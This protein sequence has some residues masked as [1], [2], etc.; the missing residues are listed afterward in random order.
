MEGKRNWKARLICFLAL[1]V[2]ASVSGVGTD[3]TINQFMHRSWTAKDGGPSVVQ[4]L[5][6]TKDGFLWLGTPDGLYRFDGIAFDRFECASWSVFPLLDVRSLRATPN[7]DLWIGFG[8]GVASVLRNGNVRN[9]T[10]A[11]GMPSGGV[12]GFAQDR[13]G[14][15]WAATT[16][17]LA[18]LESD[19]WKEVGND[20]NFPGRLA[21]GIF[22]DRHGTLWVAT[23]NSIVFLPAG[24]KKFQ[25]TGLHVGEVWQFAEA[26]NGKLWMAETTRSVRPVPLNNERLPRDSTEVRVGS[27]AILFDRDGALWITTLGDGMRRAAVPTK[28]LG[29]IGEFSTTVE[30]FSIKDGLSADDATAILQDNEGNVWVGTHKGLDCFR[31]TNLAPVALPFSAVQAVL[32][33]GDNGDIWVSTKVGPF[34]TR[35]HESRAEGVIPAGFREP[36]LNSYRSPDGINWWV[37]G[38]AVYRS[39]NGRF[40][41]IPLP[42]G[43]FTPFT[44]G[45]LVAEDGFHELWAAAGNNGLFRLKGNRWTKF[46]AGPELE[47]LIPAAAF[48]DWMGRVWFGYRGGTIAILGG[49][50]IEKVFSPRQS[51][52]GSVRAIDGVNGHV[53][54]GGDWGLA[55]LQGDNFHR[56]IPVDADQFRTVWGIVET[57]EG[58]LWLSEYR[59]VTHLPSAEVRKALDSR[60]YRVKYELFDSLDGLPG[61]FREAG[62]RSK[63]IKANDGR[64]WFAASDGIATLDPARTFRNELPPPVSILSVRADEKQFPPKENVTLPA[65]T[66]NLQIR[67]TGLSLSVPE[68]VYF[69]YKLEGVDND[70]QDA[71]TRRE[72]FYTNLRPGAY[73]FRVVASN[74]DGVWNEQGAALDFSIA[75]AWF[76]TIWFRVFCIAITMLIAWGIYRLRLRQIAKAMSAHFNDRLAERTRLARELHDTFLQTLQASKFVTDDALGNL[77]DPIR[78]RRALEQ[79]SRWLA[80]AMQEWRT[81]LHSLRASSTEA[82]D[83]A[84]AFRRALEDCRRD[85]STTASLSVTGD[86][87]ELHPVVRDEI[88][89]IGYEAIRNAC[90]HSA[91]SRI[92]VTLSY[93]D[94][95]LLEVCDNGIGIDPVIATAGKDGHFG[96]P[97][98]R[99][100]ASHIGARF[101]IANSATSGTQVR[102]VVPGRVVFRKPKVTRIEKI[103]MVLTRFFHP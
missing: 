91:G 99:E 94:D 8:F 22:V 2:C 32:S 92:D 77:Q 101:A 21:Y 9:Y 103:K 28:L 53:W 14:T 85:T 71:N 47:R 29:K 66:G 95:L 72:A 12:L 64:I 78:T 13:E 76:Q 84:A 42:K 4:A 31:K 1:F 54:V 10:A 40:S 33:A 46:D 36:I 87:R 24:T 57:S 18:R 30:S 75:P 39:E 37:S 65:L 70:W 5:A 79:L 44:G 90:A 19:R 55:V 58:D 83:L 45:F 68:R 17:G 82:N 25:P 43:L 93:A 48:T 52:V 7:G 35:I 11:D 23:E 51:L 49:R 38:S 96:L 50:T 100:R 34:M 102:V 26:T 81:A 89:R 74:N 41:R 80:R 61:T 63:E 73:R 16:A 56:I 6:Q 20:W 27:T 60:D 15:I 98:M 86:A 88:Y 97:G 69:R 3:R 59:G 62:W 67:Y